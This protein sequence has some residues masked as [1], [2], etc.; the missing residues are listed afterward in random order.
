M[1]V[2]KNSGAGRHSEFCNCQI[3]TVK[4]KMIR[5]EILDHNRQFNKFTPYGPLQRAYRYTHTRMA[6]RQGQHQMEHVEKEWGIDRLGV[7]FVP[8]M[9]VP[10]NEKHS[11][12]YH[13]AKS[14]RNNF[15]GID[16]VDLTI[17]CNIAGTLRPI[18]QTWI[19][20]DEMTENMIPIYLSSE[21]SSLY[22][23]TL[24]SDGT[25]SVCR[26][27]IFQQIYIIS[28]NITNSTGSRTYSLPI[29]MFL[30]KKRRKDN[31]VE[32]LK[33]LKDKYNTLNFKLN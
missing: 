32:I 14:S 21:L 10:A 4:D 27:S 3:V 18:D 5:N 17:L 13:Q 33:F 12:W 15:E 7:N 30:T 24:F 28:K 1:N 8:K 31:Y 22:M 19:H 20:L 16:P 2:N 26:N 9:C 11:S 6:M 29:C 23:G 25:F